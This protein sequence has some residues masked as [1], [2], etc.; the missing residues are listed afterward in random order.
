MSQVLE[1]FLILFRTRRHMSDYARELE[2]RGIPYELSG[3][4]AFKD[5][6]E[7]RTLLPLLQTL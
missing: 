1:D 3:G 7:L 5:S 6:E 2:A 4:G